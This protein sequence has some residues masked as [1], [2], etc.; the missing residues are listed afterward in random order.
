MT[1]GGIIAGLGAGESYVK[2][3]DATSLAVIGQ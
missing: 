1:K 2:K 3:W